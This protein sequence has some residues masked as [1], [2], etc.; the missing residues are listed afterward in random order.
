MAWVSKPRCWHHSLRLFDVLTANTTSHSQEACLAW[1]VSQ[2]CTRTP[3]RFDP[4]TTPPSPY[5]DCLIALKNIKLTNSLGA[6]GDFGGIDFSKL[7]G[8]AGLGG[9]DEEEEEDDEDD[10]DMPALEGEEGDKTEAKTEA[11]PAEASK[12]AA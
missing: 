9:E 3:D 12:P 10:D 8:G 11:K 2:R 6:G 1:A 4:A 5:R 7:G